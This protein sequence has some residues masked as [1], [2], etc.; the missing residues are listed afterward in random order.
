MLQ[1]IGDML[2]LK[3]N[4]STGSRMVLMSVADLYRSLKTWNCWQ[5]AAVGSS[6]DIVKPCDHI[7]IQRVKLLQSYEEEP[8]DQCQGE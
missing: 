8:G 2:C 7:M 6:V 5:R 1:E 3:E 4:H